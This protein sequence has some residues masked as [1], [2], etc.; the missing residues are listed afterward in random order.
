MRKVT[1]DT[2]ERPDSPAVQFALRTG[3]HVAYVSVSVR[4][5][6][7]TDFEVDLKPLNQIVESGVWGE[8]RWGQALWSGGSEALKLEEILNIIA[9]G[10]F[11]RDRSNLSDGQRHQLRDAMILSAHARDRR[12]VF[13][14][15]D[16]KAFI[17]GDRR[18]KLEA[19]ALTR[20]L[21]AIQFI[22]EFGESEADA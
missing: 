7:G 13:V 5:A 21:S 3:W 4:E 18:E 17:K 15:G 19:V 9:N 11:P 2:T 1:F 16:Q 6:A 22:E 10:S 14:T 12:D 20:I 8:S